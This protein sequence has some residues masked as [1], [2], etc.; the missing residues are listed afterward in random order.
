MGV[1][2]QN[3][4]RK[5]HHGSINSTCQGGEILVLLKRQARELISGPSPT[6][7]TRLMSFNK[8]KS[9]VVNGL[10]TGHITL[11]RYL[12]LMRLTNSL[13]CRRCGEKDDSS[14]DVLCE[15]K[16]LASLRFLFLGP[17]GHYDYILITNLMH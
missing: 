9:R 7:K 6:A 10:L 16:D 1:S 17:K 13:L 11:R 15:F 3:I 2:R 12:H 14:A 5:I 4:K 8:T